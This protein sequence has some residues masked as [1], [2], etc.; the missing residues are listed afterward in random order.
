LKEYA[1]EGI[2]VNPSENDALPE[3]N[4]QLEVES[5]NDSKLEPRSENNSQAFDQPDE[6]DLGQS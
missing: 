1:N 2:I 3:F 4:S 5:G 6:L